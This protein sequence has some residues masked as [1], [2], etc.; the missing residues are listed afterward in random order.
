MQGSERGQTRPRCLI[1]GS[2]SR[3]KAGISRIWG[4]AES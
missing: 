2:G 3:G 4:A 1:A